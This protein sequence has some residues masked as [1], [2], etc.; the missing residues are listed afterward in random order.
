MYCKNNVEDLFTTF[1]KSSLCQPMKKFLSTINISIIWSLGLG[2]E[3]LVSH[4][5]GGKGS[6][7]HC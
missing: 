7:P 4:L 5:Q 2:E 3:F 6:G 1:E